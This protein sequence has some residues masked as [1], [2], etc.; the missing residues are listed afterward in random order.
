VLLSGF[1]NVLL[2]TVLSGFGHVS[3]T[4]CFLY[5]VERGIVKLFR[6]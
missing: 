6:T 4:V 2:T 3:C 5:R 1:A